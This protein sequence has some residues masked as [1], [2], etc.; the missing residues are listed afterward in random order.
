[1]F[2]A[3]TVVLPPERPAPPKKPPARGEDDAVFGARTVVLGRDD[4]L[5]QDSSDE[6]DLS[7]ALDA[8]LADATARQ[9]RP[10]NANPQ[11]SYSRVTLRGRHLGFASPD[12]AGSLTLYDP[13][14]KKVAVI[15]GAD[16]EYRVASMGAKAHDSLMF[17]E[18]DDLL[19]AIAL[20]FEVDD[21]PRLDPPLP[22]VA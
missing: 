12:A 15:A 18:A 17:L 5:D 14:G 3:Q 9:Q 7:D 20:A 4:G 21:A 1:M 10:P 2:G 6:L 16:G 13:A 19:G 8:A 11:R 22:G